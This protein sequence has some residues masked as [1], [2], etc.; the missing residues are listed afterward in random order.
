MN[1]NSAPSNTIVVG[2]RYTAD[3]DRSLVSCTMYIW[4]W[5]YTM[6]ILLFFAGVVKVTD[7]L[8]PKNLNVWWTWD[9]KHGINMHILTEVELKLHLL[10]SPPQLFHPTQMIPGLKHH[11]RLHSLHDAA[12]QTNPLYIYPCS[13]RSNS[14]LLI[15]D[16]TS[17]PPLVHSQV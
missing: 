11:W 2:V 10:P 6:C 9:H 5:T 15:H 16:D 1:V 3:S 13:L 7:N 4:L 14:P 17:T 12:T 8:A